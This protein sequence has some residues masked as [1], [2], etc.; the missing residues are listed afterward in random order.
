MIE[1]KN[2]DKLYIPVEKLEYITKYSGKE[3]T[4]PKLNKLGSHDWEKTK[5]RAK[6]H[7]EDIAEELLEIYAQR[8]AKKVSLLK[9]IVKN[10]MNL[11][12]NSNMKKHQ[13]KQE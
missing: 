1:Y 2:N 9:K 10:N 13:I 3:S 12:K 11:K 6:K 7:A 8:E 5:A 4:P